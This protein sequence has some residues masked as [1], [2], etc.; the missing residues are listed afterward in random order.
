MAP[1]RWISLL[2][3]AGTILIAQLERTVEP[4]LIGEPSGSAPNMFLHAFK[5]ILPHSKIELEVSR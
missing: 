1:S 5:M 4:I 3:W 2:S